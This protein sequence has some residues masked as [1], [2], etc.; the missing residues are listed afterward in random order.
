VKRDPAEA[1]RWY[2]KAAD[3]GLATAQYELSRASSSGEGVARNPVAA[4]VWMDL[5]VF[6][7]RGAAQKKY[8]EARDAMTPH[9][10]VEQLAEAKRRVAE[11]KAKWMK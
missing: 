7:A 11:W 5:A 1:V 3:L 4:Y 8:S 9:L 6:R 2:Q 10:T